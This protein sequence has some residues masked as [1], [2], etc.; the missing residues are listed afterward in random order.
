MVAPNAE[1]P[2]MCRC[3]SCEEIRKMLNYSSSTPQAAPPAD[4][5]DPGGPL[6]IPPALRKNE[7][8]GKV[9][10]ECQ[11][12]PYTEFTRSLPADSQRDLDTLALVLNLLLPSDVTAQRSCWLY[13]VAYME[14]AQR[15]A[16]TP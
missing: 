6:R 11:S 15:D 16:L 4:P 12:P 14:T 2:K 10:P 5:D 1:H 7:S 13:V 8:P 3:K 9:I